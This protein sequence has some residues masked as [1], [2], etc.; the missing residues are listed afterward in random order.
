VIEAKR[1]KHQAVVD[2]LTEHLAKM[3][4]STAALS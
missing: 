3:D 2:Y 4:M 1:F